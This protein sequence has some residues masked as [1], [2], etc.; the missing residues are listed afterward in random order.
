MDIWAVVAWE[1]AH[2]GSC[3]LG[4]YPW[5]VAVWENVFGKVPNI[6]NFILKNLL[7]TFNVLDIKNCETCSLKKN[8]FVKSFLFGEEKHVM[9]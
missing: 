3:H 2:L 6:E 8:T 9:S 7:S 1:I 5:E 4:K